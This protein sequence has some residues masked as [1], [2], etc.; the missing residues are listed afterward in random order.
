MSKI[1][2]I[3]LNNIDYDIGN[4]N[5][6]STDEQVVGTWI[7]GKPLYRKVVTISNITFNAVTKYQF[8]ENN[9]ID[10]VFIKK[11]IL[12]NTNDGFSRSG[13]S[14]VTSDPN[15]S[16]FIQVV[17][18]T[19]ASDKNTIA[20]KIRSSNDVY[21]LSFVNKIIVILEYTKTTDTVS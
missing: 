1:D 19:S 17:N 2:K 14:P 9:I 6:Y 13:T 18:S 15:Y 5:T 7:D 11:H 10:F 20:Y 4:N 21:D 3:R 8:E 16:F 12:I